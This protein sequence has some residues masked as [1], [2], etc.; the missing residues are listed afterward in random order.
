MDGH[1]DV[2]IKYAEN[3]QKSDRERATVCVSVQKRDQ[4]KERDQRERECGVRRTKIISNAICVCGAF[5]MLYKN[6]VIL[7]PENERKK[8]T[9]TQETKTDHQPSLK[10]YM[11]LGLLQAATFFSQFGF[12]AH[13]ST[14]FKTFNTLLQIL[15]ALS[16][17]A[18]RF[19]GCVRCLRPSA[20]GFHL[21]SPPS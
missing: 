1:R 12:R 9:A 5:V 20:F 17:S 2:I 19:C 21:L 11:K 7:F 14:K 16:H 10:M 8:R 6:V 15:S 4:W 13:S 18:S 3:E